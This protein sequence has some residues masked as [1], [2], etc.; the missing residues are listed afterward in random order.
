VIR[1]LLPQ[2]AGL[3]VIRVQPRESSDGHY[4]TLIEEAGFW[5]GAPGAYVTRASAF[6]ALSNPTLAEHA[7][8]FLGHLVD[9]KEP[10]FLVESDVDDL[11]AHPLSPVLPPEL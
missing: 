10:V 6:N 11:Y 1:A 4:L 7:N 3:D 2:D 8:H 5:G 9:G